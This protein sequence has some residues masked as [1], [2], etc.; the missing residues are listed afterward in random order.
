MK[1]TPHQ[2]CIK[3]LVLKIQALQDK[4]GLCTQ[5]RVLKSGWSKVQFLQFPRQLLDNN[6]MTF[7]FPDKQHELHKSLAMVF[8]V[9]NL[10][11]QYACYLLQL[12]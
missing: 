10:S 5:L 12:N 11:N 6:S 9:Y 8:T 3:Q 1:E 2:H 4:L 7:Q